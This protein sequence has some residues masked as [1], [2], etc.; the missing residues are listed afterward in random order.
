M[1]Y[2]RSERWKLQKELDILER[3]FE[4]KS[5]VYSKHSENK[6]LEKAKK[7]FQ[8]KREII[9]TEISSIDENIK[10]I[11]T[12][13]RMEA[14]ISHK[15]EWENIKSELIGYPNNDFRNFL[16]QFALVCIKLK[17]SAL[18]LDE[19]YQEIELPDEIINESL[20]IIKNNGYRGVCGIRA[21]YGFI[22]TQFARE[23]SEI[24]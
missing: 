1:D 12:S 20:Q 5:K 16:K 7:D 18:K 2:L 3:K 22:S 13:K 11:E 17:R 21:D 15:H 24:K 9:E 23:L 8:I 4:A 10:K 14:D 6:K 19:L